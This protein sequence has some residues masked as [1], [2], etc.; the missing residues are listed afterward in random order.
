MLTVFVGLFY[1]CFINPVGVVAGVRRQ[2]LALPILI[3]LH[4]KPVALIQISYY[5]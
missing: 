4:H 2:R 3:C 5:V 1:V